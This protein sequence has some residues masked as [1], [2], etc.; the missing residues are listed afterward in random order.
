MYENVRPQMCVSATRYLLVKPFFKNYEYQGFDTE[1]L[2]AWERSPLSE[3]TSSEQSSLD[4]ITE[5]SENA[6]QID[7]QQPNSSQTDNT[8]ESQELT[9]G[10]DSDTWSEDSAENLPIGETDTMMFPTF[11][12]E[13]DGQ[14][15]VSVAPS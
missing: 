15:I 4:T 13:Y 8:E 1:W 10:D 2:Q 12:D 6:A 9:N 3:F 11:T 5:Q 7:D 14:Q